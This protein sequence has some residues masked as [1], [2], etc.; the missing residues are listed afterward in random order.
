MVFFITGGSRGIG[1]GIVRDLLT[2][3][4]DVAF[5]YATR[6]DLAADLTAW[7]ATHAPGRRCRAYALDVR[8]S[9]AV[10]R[11]AD[12]VLADFDTIDAAVLNAAINRMGLTISMSDED[13]REVMDVNV[14]GAFYVC[15]QLLPAFLA[16]RSGRFI[17]ISSIAVYG[18]AGLAA[19]SASKAALC[20]FSASLSKEYGP[21][22]ITSNVLTLGFF[23][24]D[25]SRELMPDKQKAFWYE[26]CPAKRMGTAADVSQ[27]VLYLASPGA[28][29][30]NGETLHLTGGLRW[31]P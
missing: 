2:A 15:R 28:A 30:V 29:F 9:S 14:T 4:H 19:Y 18:M 16:N 23:D 24:T 11:V 22:G 6:A 21:K 13:W 12:A 31:A 5:T 27:A 26:T 10:E 20:G 1:A 25:M 8:D 17:H 7:A 3:G